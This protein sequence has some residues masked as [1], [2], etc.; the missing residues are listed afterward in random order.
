MTEQYT[1]T[2]EVRTQNS[3]KAKLIAGIL[4]M[5]FSLVFLIVAILKNY[6]FF[7]GFGV[8][9]VIGFALV[10]IFESAPSEFIYSISPKNLVISKKNNAHNTK[11][12]AC[13]SLENVERI[14]LFTDIVDSGDLVCCEN[15]SEKSVYALI[16]SDFDK[17]FEV[18]KH[19]RL[20]FCP[21]EYML[22]LL[23]E[24]FADKFVENTGEVY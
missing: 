7:I 20:L 19:K 5:M 9:I 10:Q 6:L 8:F 15:S 12:K 3:D 4:C 16:Y 13:I 21:D 1:Q 2:V 18:E 22:A 24:N 14:E 17:D 11:R 23:K